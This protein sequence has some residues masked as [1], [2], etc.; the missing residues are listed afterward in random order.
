MG[1]LRTVGKKLADGRAARLERAKDTNYTTDT[2]HGSTHD[3]TEMDASK[4]NIEGDWGKGIYSSN[5]IY[6]VNE[7][8]AGVG[9]DLTARI[10]QEADRLESQLLDK[11]EERG[12]TTV[13]ESLR[14]SRKITAR[15]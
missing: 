5:N 2:F 13:L 6:D 14:R 9:P 11:F 7:N 4:T 3:L 1:M 8:Y 15:D 10:E 12:R